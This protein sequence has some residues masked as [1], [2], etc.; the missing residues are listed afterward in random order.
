MAV[1][2]MAQAL[3]DVVQESV[4]ANVLPCEHMVNVLRLLYLTPA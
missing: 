4:F 2:G 3:E 1:V